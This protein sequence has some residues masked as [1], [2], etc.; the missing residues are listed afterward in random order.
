M[1]VAPRRNVTRRE[2]DGLP[3]FTNGI[4]GGNLFGG[5]FVSKWNRLTQHNLRAVELNDVVFCEVTTRYGD[6]IVGSK[7]YCGLLILHNGSSVGASWLPEPNR[8]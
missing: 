7:L 5:D 2:T 1:Y 8:P 6:V 4:T 3:K